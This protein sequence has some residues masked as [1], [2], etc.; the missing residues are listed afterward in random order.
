M[1]RSSQR[2][3]TNP[4]PLGNRFIKAARGTFSGKPSGFIVRL[5]R[6]TDDDRLMESARFV[7][8]PKILII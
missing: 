8:D 6:Y 2:A 7:E 5:A 1:D 4:T 3:G